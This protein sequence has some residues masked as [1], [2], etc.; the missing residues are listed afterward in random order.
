MRED[1]LA[2]SAFALVALA[3][4]AARADD[5]ADTATARALGIEGVTLADAGKC[6]D[7][8]PKLARSDKLHHAPTTAG[9]LGECEIAV[10]KLVA[11]T[12][13]LQRVVREVLPANAHPAFF[14]AVARAQR[15]LDA[16]VARIAQLHVTVVVPAG[17][18]PTVALDDEALADTGAEV[19][20]R[21]DPGSHGIRAI[22]PGYLAKSDVVVLG[23]GETKSVVLELAPDPDAPRAGALAPAPPVIVREAPS[24]LPA[25]IAFGLA[26]A[27]LA[28]GI[29]AGVVTGDEA[30]KLARTCDPSRVCPD[31]SAGDLAS[32]KKWATVSTV[33]FATAG[34]GLVTGT[35]WLLLAR[36]GSEEAP[37]RGR[38]QVRPRVGVMSVGVDGRF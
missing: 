11:G 27:G 33:G 8:I 22:A 15:V 26:G 28:V 30:R 16:N 36:G 38:V 17:V 24:K 2:A 5:A 14:A 9:R 12:E 21:L 34:A 4:L 13:R 25:V 18:K 3:P 20:R 23:E 7:A 32:A 1:L 6:R 37:P 35:L 10:G 29:G 19:E 31:G